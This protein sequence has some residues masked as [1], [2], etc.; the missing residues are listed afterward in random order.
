MWPYA[1]RGSRFLGEVTEA[2][3]SRLESLEFSLN[4]DPIKLWLP[5]RLLAAIDVLCGIHDASRPDV[6]RTIFFEHAFGRVEMAHLRRRAAL[7]GRES[8]G[9]KLSPRR[10]STDLTAR[11]INARFLGKATEDVKL[12]VPAALK[13]ELE[14]LARSREQALSDYLRGVLARELLGERLYQSWQQALAEANTIARTHE[15]E[16]F[17]MSASFTL[18]PEGTSGG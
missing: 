15:F 2:S 12:F 3:P 13:S 9:V 7:R 1:S 4:G 6:L 5:E 8:P 14:E 11:E 10:I 16:R 18:T 17:T